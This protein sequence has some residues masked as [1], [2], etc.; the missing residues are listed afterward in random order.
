MSIEPAVL[1]INPFECKA[2]AASVIFFQILLRCDLFV[3]N[4]VNCHPFF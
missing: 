2:V 1:Y 3:S 4:F